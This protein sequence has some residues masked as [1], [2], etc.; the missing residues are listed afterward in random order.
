MLKTDRGRKPV[1]ANAT[2]LK[3]EP[4]GCWALS[5]DL[6]ITMRRCRRPTVPRLVPGF[7]TWPNRY[8]ILRNTRCRLMPRCEG[9]ATIRP[10]GP[11]DRNRAN[12]AKRAG[13]RP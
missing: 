3:R 12:V 8:A 1:T 4:L 13:S 6:E 2:N 10:V 11:G 9:L 5:F 7:M